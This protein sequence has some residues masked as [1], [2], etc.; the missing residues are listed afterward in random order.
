MLSV[1]TKIKAEVLSGTTV[2][3][4]ISDSTC[5][6]ISITK[7][8]CLSRFWDVVFTHPIL[9]SAGQL[10]IRFLRVVFYPVPWWF[11]RTQNQFFCQEVVSDLCLDSSYAWSRPSCL[12]ISHRKTAI[13]INKYYPTCFKVIF[14]INGFI[15]ALL[16][17]TFIIL[18]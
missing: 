13:D 5:V 4:L 1:F 6:F 8:G 14:M 15:S 9:S 3:S 16:Q 17:S 12:N 7:S 18:L 2:K 11:W 10:L